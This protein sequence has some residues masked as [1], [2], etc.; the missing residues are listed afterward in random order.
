VGLAN[1]P[2]TTIEAAQTLTIATID[3]DTLD[4]IIYNYGG[5]EN[6]E[7][8]AVLIMNKLTLLEFAKVKDTNGR[9]VYDIVL[10][11][12]TATIN[13]IGVVLTSSMPAYGT[14]SNG[15]AYL[16]YGKLSGYELTEFSDVD[17]AVSKDYKFKQGQICFKASQFCGGAPS[18]FNGFTPVI[19]ASA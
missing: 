13:G 19:K 17:V 5:D 4:T 10:R 12:N 3:E 7:D 11:G 16:F 2:V 8:D 6:V 1:A 18:M 15:T 14:V 9:H